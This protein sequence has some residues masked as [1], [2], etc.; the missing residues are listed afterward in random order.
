MGAK[1]SQAGE[2][3][4]R[5]QVQTRAGREAGSLKG[6]ENIFEHLGLEQPAKPPWARLPP[7][8]WGL[9]LGQTPGAALTSFLVPLQRNP[10]HQNLPQ[11][12]RLCLPGLSHPRA[13]R[14]CSQQD[15][16]LG[17]W[18]GPRSRTARGRRPAWTT[19][20]RSPGNLLNP[21]ASPGQGGEEGRVGAGGSRAAGG[22]GLGSVQEASTLLSWWWWEC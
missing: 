22:Q 20:T 11:S 15:L 10:K 8:P 7:G 18:S 19:P 5:R 9:L 16:R 3:S 1:E 21:I 13:L 6:E 4:C 12:P 14:G 17:A 2:A